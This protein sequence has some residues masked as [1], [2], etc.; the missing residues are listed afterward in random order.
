MKDST[1][2]FLPDLFQLMNMTHGM[3]KHKI[4][5]FQSRQITIAWQLKCSTGFRQVV[6]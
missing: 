6:G 4:R 5:S 3:V 1:C 2:N